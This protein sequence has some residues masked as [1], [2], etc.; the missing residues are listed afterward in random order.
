MSEPLNRI[1]KVF[2]SGK[3]AK[4]PIVCMWVLGI[5]LVLP[6]NY[7]VVQQNCAQKWSMIFEKCHTDTENT[8]QYVQNNS[9]SNVKSCWTTLYRDVFGYDCRIGYCTM[10][11]TEARANRA[12]SYF[13]G[14]V[15]PFITIVLSNTALWMMVRKSSTY[16]RNSRWVVT[17]QLMC[18]FKC[19][20][21]KNLD[22]FTK[23]TE[24]L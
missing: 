2:F 6:H 20:N 13:I 3:A 22:L 1:G 12:M 23:F 21:V 14:F 18:R 24:F 16:L 15:L 5:G 10:I 19:I 8:M 9:T 7:R 11:K 17:L 4:L